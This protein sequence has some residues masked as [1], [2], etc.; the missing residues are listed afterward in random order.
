[1]Y[2]TLLLKQ[3]KGVYIPSERT[4]YQAMDQIALSQRP[5]RKPNGSTKAD[6][7]AMKSEELLKRDFR[8]DALWENV[9]QIS[10]KPRYPTENCI[11]LRFFDCV[12]LGVLSL[13][14][15]T[16]MKADLCVHTLEELCPQ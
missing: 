14:V 16:N 9:L 11:Y 4:V 10:R 5:H 2:Q 6:R 7:E 15:E 13:L 8:L 12:D 3:L 1:M